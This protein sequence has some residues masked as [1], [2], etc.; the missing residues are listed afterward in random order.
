MIFRT[1]PIV[2]ALVGLSIVI[3]VGI[4]VV[5]TRWLPSR[6]SQ[7]SQIGIVQTAQAGDLH[8]RMQLDELAIGPR[9]IDIL[10]NDAAGRPADVNTVRLRFSM[11]EM[12]M[13]TVEAD[14]RPVSRGRFQAQGTF[15]TMAGRWAIEA[16][17]GREAQT[18]LSA[19]FTFPIAAPGEVS[20]PLNPL[21]ADEPTRAA[22]RL[23]YQANCAVCHGITGQGNGPGSIGLR[24]APGDFTQ[25]MQPG[26]H[27]D[28]QVFLWINDGYPQTAM[29]AW[30]NR[31][32]E[33]QIWQLVTYLRTFGVITATAATDAATQATTQAPIAP[34]TAVPEIREP[35]PPLVFIRK[36]N[37]WRSDRSQATPRQITDLPADSYAEYPTFSP[38]GNR[39][40]FIVTTQGPITETTP[41]PL[42][43]PNTQLYIMGID[44]SDLRMIWD[45]ARGV[46]G[47]P[48]WGRDSQALYVPIAD[49]LSPP[50]APVADRL[51]QIMRVDSQT[52]VRQ[53]E[54]DGGYEV[55]VASSGKQRVFL[56]WHA[57]I[58]E[59]T[60]NIIDSDG[61]NEREVISYGKFS[62]MAVPRLS[63][64]GRQ[65]IFASTT[66]PVT[67]PQ[68]YP[69]NARTQSP[70]EQLLGLFTPAVAEGHGSL[71]E[72]WII[73]IDGTGLRR[74]TDLGLDTP[75]AVFSPDG[76]QIAIMCEGGIY[77]MNTD[78]TS[79]R[80]IDP[81]GDHGGLDWAQQ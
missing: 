43:I 36:G 71:S 52:S 23:L 38:D 25:H 73:N 7:V 72:L 68:G 63:P 54:T 22:G 77:L 57:K 40:A 37:V 30:G 17:V 24:P 47:P 59:F 21:T 41:L 66:G 4:L 48:A 18:P 19:A 50:D 65:I 69:L 11:A 32:N 1:R 67:D 5:L 6:T 60:L 78:G 35:L 20:G 49:I 46:L 34:P 62:N 75:T 39:I 70:F 15:F 12:D 10:V 27:T 44:G 33:K 51:F 58:A 53:L 79:V 80:K 76:T 14:A 31:L 8:V 42:P 64:D 56:R 13:G 16:I 28:G 9:V 81:I 61:R 55:T 74:L 45:P 29:P 3:V 2:L 26:K